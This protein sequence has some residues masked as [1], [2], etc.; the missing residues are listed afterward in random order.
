MSG[1]TTGGAPIPTTGVPG[2]TPVPNAQAAPV[3]QPAAGAST[4]AT[5]YDPTPINTGGSVSGGGFTDDLSDAATRIVAFAQGR[6][7]EINNNIQA[8]FKSEGGDV[9]P[10]K[11]QYY[12]NM[13]NQYELMMQQAAK[14]QESKERALQ[15][16]M[17]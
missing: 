1:V 6:I 8:L 10:A 9:D 11:L 14:L 12:N 15:A 13:L 7:T 4:V 3:T 17:R 2:G 16:L 5:T